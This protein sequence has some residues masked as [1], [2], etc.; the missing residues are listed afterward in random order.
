[1]TNEASTGDQG[2]NFV[3]AVKKTA[4]QR[5]FSPV[6]IIPIVAVVIGLFLIFKVVTESGPTITVTFK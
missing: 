2:N 6:W 5:G 3:N 1:M 4:K